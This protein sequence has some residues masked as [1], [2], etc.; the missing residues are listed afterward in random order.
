MNTNSVVADGAQKRAMQSTK[1]VDLVG[2]VHEIEQEVTRRQV[3]VGLGATAAVAV[4]GMGLSLRSQRA[5]GAVRVNEP[6]QVLPNVVGA[7]RASAAASVPG[8]LVLVT[9][10]GGNDGLNTLVPYADSAYQAAR[11][12]VA[13]RPDEVLQ[14][15]SQFGLHPSMTGMK[16]LWDQ[17]QL[18]IV[19]GVGYPDPNRSHFRSMDIWQSGVPDRYEVSGWLGRWQ[20][21]TS[22]DPL[23]MLS[24]GPSVPR[25]LVGIKG[26]GGSALPNG[27]IALPGG[28]G[29]TNAF[30]DLGRGA[31][32]NELGPWGS[33]VGTSVANLVRVIEKLGP[34]LSGAVPE[35]STSLEGGAAANGD[36]TSVLDTQLN[37][38]ATLIAGGAPAR[39]YS[40]ALGGFDTH[41]TEHEQHARLLSTVD[42]A[43][44]R[45]IAK[46]AGVAAAS[47]VTILVYSEFGRRVSANLSGGTD[48]GTAAPVFV[49]GPRVQGGFYGDAPSLTDLDQ[50]DLKFTTDYRNV[51]ASMLAQVLTVD[52]AVALGSGFTPIPL[53]R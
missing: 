5:E 49:L 1:S 22:T 4:G 16:K 31:A 52:P 44:S 19:R 40:V 41:A 32:G 39:V 17:K 12:G 37:E 42:G 13:F 51:Y 38:V 36:S 3:L 48:H 23:R 53:V 15:D 45:F 28:L 18:A 20:D 21:A 30:A 34:L 33:Q 7:P 47:N 26:G 25:A 24:L 9:L 11:V 35:V 14:L 10:Y 29:V 50:G 46:T 43:L 8:I 27:K 6:A 2:E